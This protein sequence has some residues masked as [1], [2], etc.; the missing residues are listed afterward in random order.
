MSEV[1]SHEKTLSKIDASKLRTKFEKKAGS[2]AAADSL[3]NRPL[4]ANVS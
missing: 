2:R 4:V 1:Q 3:E